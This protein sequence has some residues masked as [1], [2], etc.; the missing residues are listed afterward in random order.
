MLRLVPAA[1]KR[2]LDSAV[3]RSTRIPYAGVPHEPDVFLRKTARSKIIKKY[4]HKS[5]LL[6][7]RGQTRLEHRKA[8]TFRRILWIYTGKR[9]FGDATMDLSGRA[10]LKGRDIEIDLFTLPTLHKLFHEDDVFRNVFHDLREVESRQYDAVLMSE[11]N[12]PSIKL[13]S[14]YFKNLPFASLFRFFYGPD[15]NQT[16]FSY[17]AISD[18]FSLG[19][20]EQ[21]IAALS[22]PYLASRAATTHSVQA[23]LPEQRFIALAVGGLDANR[24][25]RHWPELLDMIDRSNDATLPDRIVLLGSD[26]GQSMADALLGRTFKRL[27]VSSCVG[28]LSLLQSR[29]V[30]AHASLFVG[31]DG[32]LMHVA[33]STP[34]PSV[35]LFSNKEPPALRLTER[36]NS[37]GIQSTGD[38]DDIAPNAVFDAIGK[39]LRQPLVGAGDIVELIGEIGEAGTLHEE[40][41]A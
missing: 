10:L 19:Y 15:R 5:L 8:H 28:T 24:T 25:Y 26:N 17:A 18:V 39:R 34:A 16:S 38:V 3:H 40:V 9:N 41:V 31:A 23:M 4:L 12:L 33:H 30:I 7:V 22:K 27:K 13:K 29:E 6:K 37:I 35:S 32:G 2:K 14:K 21:E 20:S 36:C 11:Y 1:L